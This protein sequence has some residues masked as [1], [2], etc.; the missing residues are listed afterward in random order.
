MLTLPLD[1][2]DDRAKPAFTDSATCAKWLAQLQLTNLH[3]AHATLRA[4]LDELNRYPMRGLERMQLL[5]QL[6]IEFVT[7]AQMLEDL[8]ATIFQAALAK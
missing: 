4:Q 5:P 8:R 6:A 2:T 7:A 3:Q 1:P